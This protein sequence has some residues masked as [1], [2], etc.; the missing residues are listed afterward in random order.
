MD[1]LIELFIIKIDI[2]KK[3]EAIIKIQNL[4]LYKFSLINETKG[5]SYLTSSTNLIFLNSA[6]NK[7]LLNL[8]LD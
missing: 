2:I 5:A 6:E 3:N 8:V 7:Y 1:N 4:I